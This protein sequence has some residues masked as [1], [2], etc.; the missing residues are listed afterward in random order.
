MPDANHVLYQLFE[1]Q[2]LI[3]THLIKDN[4]NIKFVSLEH[5]NAREMQVYMSGAAIF[6]LAQKT[7]L[8]H[9]II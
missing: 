4:K 9:S 2:Y 3:D 6:S 8:Q 7:I 5:R 1:H